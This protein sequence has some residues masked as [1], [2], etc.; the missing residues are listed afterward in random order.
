MSSDLYKMTSIVDEALINV[1]QQDV[2]TENVK[3][4]KKELSMNKQASKQYLKEFFPAMAAYVIVVL[5]SSTL[6]NFM[7]GTTWWHIPIALAPVVPALFALLAYMR[8]IKRMDEMQR[9][10]QF[11]AIAFSFACTG[12]LTFSYGFLENIGF[13][14][15]GLIFIWPLMI[16][17]WGIGSAI[18]SWRYR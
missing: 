15:L 7:P 12:V 2:H 11:G 14:H 17:L 9:Q 4:R 8:Y 16:A 13:P 3:Q 5:I 18:I 1:W 10:I 6:L